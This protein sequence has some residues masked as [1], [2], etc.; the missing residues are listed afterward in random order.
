MGLT[1]QDVMTADLS[2]LS[3]VSDAWRKMGDRF[4][5]LKDDY[6]KLVPRALA[7]GKWE[8]E[9]FRAHQKTATATGFEYAAA[10]QEALALAGLLKQAHIKLTGLQKSLRDLVGDA[11][12]KDFKVDS[13]GRA[14]YVGLD[15]PS[16]DGSADN[17]PDY[18]AVTAK[19]RSAAQEWTERIAD[20]VRAVDDADQS[21]RRAL[22]RAAGGDPAKRGG[23]IGFNPYADGNLDKPCVAP[24]G[25]ASSDGT[26]WQAEGG[27][28]LTGPGTD[29]AL[30]GPGYG[31]QGMLKL[32]ADG[33]HVT[34][35][36][37]LTDGHRTFSGIADVYGGARVTGGLDIS[38]TGV[39]LNGEA[40]AGVRGMAEGRAEAGNFG[41]YGRGTGFAGAEASGDAKMDLT[42][43]FEF[44]GKL[45]AGAK[46]GA[47]AGADVGGIGVGVT[48]EDWKAV[49]VEG[50]LIS[51]GE[52][53][54]YHLGVKGGVGL[55]PAGLGL[56][57]EFTVE[58]GKVV[59]TAKDA[60][61][62][63]G[64]GAGKV[65]DI[66]GGVTDGLRSLRP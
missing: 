24:A 53:G 37:K 18:A 55:G 39:S 59:D 43:G 61:G 52:D 47:A 22:T 50:K 25:G 19:A 17:D 49:G 8:G 14:T 35:D 46:Y 27:V 38:D 56:G 12:A 10:R 20:A 33:F 44:G 1:Y 41:V 4:G 31:R 57:L 62:A 7:N 64:D 29:Y 5:E 66:A 32:A 9:A 45:F 28:V 63:L 3:D 65:K 54:K 60:A 42:Q 36:G 6:E 21:V 58:P 26:S 23:A 51:R 15:K 2:P 30:S 34:A 40:S 48:Y 11:E 16:P 13:S